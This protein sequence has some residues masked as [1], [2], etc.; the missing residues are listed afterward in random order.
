MKYFRKVTTID[1][2]YN[3]HKVITGTLMTKNVTEVK[4]KAQNKVTRA[5]QRIHH[6]KLLQ[7][8]YPGIKVK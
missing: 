2:G 5:T 4:I 3:E 8:R 1:N 7:V 6:V